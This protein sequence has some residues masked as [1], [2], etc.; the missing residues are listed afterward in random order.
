[1]IEESRKQESFWS[2]KNPILYGLVGT[3]L[4]FA[5]YTYLASA[6]S[7]QK[8]V[9]QTNFKHFL[10]SSPNEIGD[11]LAGIAGILA[12]LW[13]IITVFLQ[14][15]ELRTARQ[16]YEKMADAQTGQLDLLEKQGKIFEREQEEREMASLARLT[17]ELVTSLRWKIE[18][19]SIQWVGEDDGFQ[20]GSVLSLSPWSPNG[21][22]EFS[23][24]QFFQK[25]L[26]SAQ[27]IA[28]NLDQFEMRTPIAKHPKRFKLQLIYH[29]LKVVLKHVDQLSNTERTRMSRL[30]MQKLKESLNELLGN[31][32][33]WSD[34]DD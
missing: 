17:D 21:Q 18:T 25:F 8:G 5:I 2:I 10:A 22:T 13:I 20:T 26:R 30:E 31:E 23:N 14:S 29:D 24:E 7:C 3:I 27:E 9:C 16:E 34:G 32:S 15:K 19:S 33:L 11:T 1:V 12:F 4:V 6:R 28:S